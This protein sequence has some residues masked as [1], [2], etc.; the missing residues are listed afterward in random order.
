MKRVVA[1]SGIVLAIAGGIHAAPPAWWSQ[2]NPPVIDPAAGVNNHGMANVGQA[3]WMAKRALEALR[4]TQPATADAI[5]AQLVGSG[6]PIASWDAP[7]TQEQKDAQHT[8]LLI[9]QLK[10][11][12]APFYS[13]LHDLNAAWLDDQLTQNQTKDTSDP[14]NFY[15]WSSITADDN[16]KAATTIGQLKSVF[17]LRFETLVLNGDGDGDGMPDAWEQQYF[18]GTT[19]LANGDFDGDGVP[20]GVEYQKGLLP[21]DTDTDD[22]GMTDGEEVANELDPLVD[23][24][25]EDKD[26]DRYPNIFEVKNGSNPSSS[27]ST[28]ASHYVVNPAGG[29]THTTIQSAINAATTDYK[30]IQVVAGLYQ[31][32]SN[33]GLDMGSKKLLLMSAQGASKTTLDC[34]SARRGI[35]VGADSV[36]DGFTVKNGAIADGAGIYCASGKSR[37]VNCVLLNNKAGGNGGAFYVAAGSPSFVHCTVA[38]NSAAGS[39]H[40]IYVSGGT[41]TIANGILWDSSTL[42]I[43][44]GTSGAVNV[45]YSTVCGGYAGT[46]NSNADPLLIADGHLRV[47]SPAINAA[48]PGSKVKS[49][50]DGE[51]RPFSTS[52][53]MG[54][55]EWFDG[56]GDDLADWWE[57]ARFNGMAQTAS[58]DPDTDSLNNANEYQFGTNPSLADTDADGIPDGY[59]VSNSL[60]PLDGRDLLEDKD[61]DRVPNLYEYQRGT[62]AGNASSTPGIDFTVD[63]AIGTETATVKKTIAA[64]I[65]AANSA[66]GDYKTIFV[67]R[68]TYAESNLLISSKRLALVGERG[69]T[70]LPEI[71]SPTT[72]ATVQ[73][74]YPG[75]V[76]DG[77]VIKHSNPLLSARGIYVSVGSASQVRIANCVIAGNS[78]TYGSGLYVGS[79]DCLIDHCT[80][81]GNTEPVTANPA[82][83][84]SGLGIYLGSSSGKMRL[85]NS[86]VWN[87][88]SVSGSTQIYKASGASIELI[89]SIVRNGELGALDMDPLLDRWGSLRAGSPAINMAGTTNISSMPLDI[90]GEGRVGQPD[91]GA[92]EFFDADG[93]DLPDWWELKFIGNT[94][95]NGTA[96][97]DNDGLNHL[98]EHAFGSNPIVADTDGDGANDGA[99]SSAGTNPWDT[100]SD[101]DGILDGYEI[102]KLLNPLDYRDALEDKDGDRIPNL[103]EAVLGAD[104]NSAAS[105]PAAHYTVASSGGTH[106]TI[107]AAIN[108]ANA[109]SG[110][111][112][113]ILVKK[114]TYAEGGLTLG[115]KK[116]MLMGEQNVAPPTISAPNASPCVNLN[117]SGCI[118]DGLILTHGS[119]TSGS[120]GIYSSMSGYRAQSRVVNCVI[121]ENRSAS[122]AGVYL[123]SGEL[124]VDHS[125]IHR[126]RNN[127]FDSEG[128]DGRGIYVSSNSKL[129]L[130]NSIVWNPTT[131]VGSAQIFKSSSN[132]ATV[133]LTN[134]IVLGGEFGGLASD[135]L[136]DRYGFLKAGSPA[137]NPAGGVAIAVSSQDIFGNT[138]TLPHDLGAAEYLDADNDG[139][140]DWWELRFVG[141]TTGNGTSNPDTDGLT[142]A[143][144][145]A[146]GSNPAVADTDGDGANDGAESAAG[147]DPWDTDSDDDGMT[148]G[149]EITHGLAPLDRHDA[150]EDKDGDRIP[151]LYEAVR[152]TLASNSSSKPAADYTVAATGGTHTTIAAA[153]S[154]ANSASGD[155]KVILIKKGT[156]VESGFSLG[157]KRILLLGEQGTTPPVLAAPNTLNAINLSYDG[158]VMDGLVIKHSVPVNGGIGVSINLPNIYSQ[159]RLVNCILRENY[160]NVGAGLYVNCGDVSIDHCTIVRNEGTLIA[161]Q[162]AEDGLGVYIYSGSLRLRNSIV[163]NPAANPLSTQIH[164]SSFANCEVLNCIVLGGEYG[165]TNADPLLTKNDKLR[166]GSPAINPSGGI[167]LSASSTDIEGEFRT[168]PPDIGADEFVD[169]D[170]D[171]IADSWE[172]Q[173]FTNLA[174][175]AE[176]DDD[177]PSGDGLKNVYEY[178]FELDPTKPDTDGDGL[179]DLLEAFP[180]ANTYYLLPTQIADDDGD[181]LTNAQEMM[182]GTNNAVADSNGDGI[183][184]S[185]SWA[186]G[187]NP[188]S[189]D[190]DGDGLSNAVELTQGTSPL[191]ADSDGDGVSD[192]LDKF[193][194]DSTQSSLAAVGGDV[195]APAVT[196]TKPPGAVLQP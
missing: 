105:V 63:P 23:D 64:A 120:Q 175:T 164:T 176:G 52:A 127:T 51:M 27:S 33:T 38:G 87:A 177:Q 62:A 88:A 7:I 8:P 92:D 125:T 189:T 53:D 31:G 182:L 25:F 78:D 141:N 19:Q 43:A 41:A 91:C 140:P 184:D 102:S 172:I 109:A 45:S 21:N 79:A 76:L 95:D 75:V 10:A 168:N 161:G 14:A 167:S 2:G 72:S 73:I 80:I 1:V 15:P 70:S 4:A 148:D 115:S 139:L 40:G 6:K 128:G 11:I 121:M 143:Q 129:R 58:G 112:R 138:R 187:F 136:L 158:V 188:L 97:P 160:A 30:I 180:Q 137:I 54:A 171:G 118:V 22:D 44:N 152:S 49:D 12:A 195:V 135:P 94:N 104:A 186:L 67:K 157:G 36:I 98:Q 193:P 65:S 99:E 179:S 100:D 32:S 101:D 42:E 71:V 59:E 174:K 163:W 103:Y 106:T 194:L 69:Q 61:G 13:K 26:G 170:A 190:S 55:D 156:Y 166:P 149:Y 151:N 46:G 37:F 16:N 5:E 108:A 192:S 131:T 57:L 153:I 114:G 181:G 29:G 93:D 81:F 110:D 178:L 119:T 107:L 130:R 116:I 196:L 111:C 133:E 34:Q 126:N 77:L 144:E 47:G 159:A 154:A 35:Y 50:M 124:L 173:Y 60:N 85:R 74:T 117:Y 90:H 146:F 86:I 66:A 134:S 84:V 169:S 132:T 185:V 123:G 89:G 56:D 20:N 24:R 18:G 9:G 3:K 96:N 142:H 68:A 82:A 122:G 28:P 165:G 147:T 191:M 39:G 83:P 155:C 145:Y 150:L 162:N 48:D 17:S 113:I 183:S